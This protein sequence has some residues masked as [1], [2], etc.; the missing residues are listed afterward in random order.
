MKD[1]NFEEKKSIIEDYILDNMTKVKEFLELLREL[2]IHTKYLRDNFSGEHYNESLIKQ[3]GLE[4]MFLINQGHRLTME[5][6]E[7][8]YKGYEGSVSYDKESATYQGKLLNINDLVTFEGRN[9]EEFNAAFKEA[10][11]DYIELKNSL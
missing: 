3:A 1:Y 5:I 7:Y 9:D 2:H 6:T 10:V 4:E 11:D 8:K